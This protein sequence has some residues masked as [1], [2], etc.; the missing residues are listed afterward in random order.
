MQTILNQ[1]FDLYQQDRIT[2]VTDHTKVKHASSR[3]RRELLIC[4]PS[5]CND[6]IIFLITTFYLLVFIQYNEFVSTANK[7]YPNL[8]NIPVFIIVLYIT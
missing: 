8:E 2:A 5:H 7:N 4:I 3:L 1:D 6:A